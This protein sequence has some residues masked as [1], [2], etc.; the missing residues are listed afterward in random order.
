MDNIRL[1]TMTMLSKFNEGTYV[2]NTVSEVMQINRRYLIWSYYNVEK[3]SFTDD[4]L[5]DLGVDRIEKPG[6]SKLKPKHKEVLYCDIKKK[7]VALK[8]QGLPI[9]QGLMTAYIAAKARKKIGDNKRHTEIASKSEMRDR[10]R[11]VK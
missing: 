8:I 7:I 3:L 9:S 11:F 6:I 2:N 1:R 4:V 5:E 10:N